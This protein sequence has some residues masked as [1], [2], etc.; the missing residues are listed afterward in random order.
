MKPCTA[1]DAARI[2]GMIRATWPHQDVPPETKSLM[3]AD[4]I[5]TGDPDTW[6]AVVRHYRYLPGQT[7]IPHIGDMLAEWERLRPQ[8]ELSEE[9]QIETA[10]AQWRHANR[11]RL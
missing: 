6:A 5:R 3:M 7:F 9:E 4:L 10:L 11:P 8:P 1:E 2:W